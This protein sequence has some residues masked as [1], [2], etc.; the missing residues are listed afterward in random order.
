M[1][2]FGKQETQLSVATA[3]NSTFA[4]GKQEG[5]LSVANAA[6]GTT[7][8]NTLFAF[9]KQETQL[10]VAN[11]V[12]GTTANNTL[13]AFGKQETQLF[14]ANSANSSAL[15][16][17]TWQ[18]PLGIGTVTANSGAFTTITASANVN[19]DVGTLFTD[20]TNNRVGINTTTPTTPLHVVGNVTVANGFGIVANG[21]IGTA[22]QALLSNGS[23]IYWSTIA[24]GGPIALNDITDVTIGGTALATGDVLRYTG[25]EWINDAYVQTILSPVSR[26][27]T[28]TLKP[29]SVGTTAPV[30]PQTGDLWVDTN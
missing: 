13:F 9:G 5:Q 29:I 18:A 30:S 20:A 4:Y 7:S 24:G 19:L 17:A 10:S 12:F 14:V 16:G 23:A 21:S 15:Q 25:T 22:G 8:N 28:Q 3:N 26:Q 2:A 6:F 27:T 11:A 1:F